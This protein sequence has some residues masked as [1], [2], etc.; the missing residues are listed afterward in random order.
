VQKY[1]TI[2]VE[3]LKIKNMVKNHHL[4]RSISDASWGEL[5]DCLE[6]K[7]EEAG[8]KIVKVNPKNTSQNCSRCGN[9]VEK[10]LAVRIHECPFCGLEMDR[11]ENA[12]R[13][14]H[15][16]GQTCQAQTKEIALCVA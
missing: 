1:G 7:A 15:Q 9:K 6:C 12:A 2:Y 11:D 4:A 8:R 16:V 10:S 14:I 5:F 3:D 13:N